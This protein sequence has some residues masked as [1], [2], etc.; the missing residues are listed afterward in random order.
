MFHVVRE[1]VALLA[2]RR[3]PPEPPYRVSSAIDKLIAPGPC[4]RRKKGEQG[5][6]DPLPLAFSSLL[7]KAGEKVEGG[8][9]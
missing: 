3:K 7:E 8:R 1:I 6:E 2:F 9:R 4:V 5:K